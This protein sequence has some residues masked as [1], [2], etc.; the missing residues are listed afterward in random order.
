M[1]PTRI[2]VG[3]LSCHR[4]VAPDLTILIASKIGPT[5]NANSDK[6]GVTS[7]DSAYGT[8]HMILQTPQNRRTM[9]IKKISPGIFLQRSNKRFLKIRRSIPA[10]ISA[11]F[12]VIIRLPRVE[13]SPSAV[14]GCVD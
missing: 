9:I 7:L 11:W 8:V 4:V 12:S 3:I 2:P 5:I 1:F 13:I 14:I 6:Y 10:H